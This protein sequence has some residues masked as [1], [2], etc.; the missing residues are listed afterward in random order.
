MIRVNYVLYQ[1]LGN[2]L[3]G[4]LVKVGRQGRGTKAR[5]GEKVTVGG[6]GEGEG[7]TEDKDMRARLG[8]ESNG[9][10]EDGG[11]GKGGGEGRGEGKCVGD[12][13]GRRQG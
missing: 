4:I 2:P 9:V 8:G 11:V 12:G 5:T 10:G 1:C 7:G 3:M 6:E 13:G